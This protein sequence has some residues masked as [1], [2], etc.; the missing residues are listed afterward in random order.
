MNLDLTPEPEKDDFI[1][2]ACGMAS[3]MATH[4][5]GSV[6]GR[7][8]RCGCKI[9]MSPTS[10]AHVEAAAAKM[11][12]TVRKLCRPCA[13]PLI[14]AP[15]TRIMPWTE[16]QKREYFAALSASKSAKPSDE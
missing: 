13:L 12:R 11:G 3:E 7:C 5:P 1:V 4:I 6:F 10:T 8:Y 15:G 14:K 2:H 16:D 9:V